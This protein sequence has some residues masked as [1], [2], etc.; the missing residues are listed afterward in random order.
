VDVVDHLAEEIK[1]ASC[2]THTAAM[3]LISD[4]QEDLQYPLYLEKRT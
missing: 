2:P 1:K 4:T 3:Q